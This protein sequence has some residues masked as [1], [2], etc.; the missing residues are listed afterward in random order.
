MLSC[1]ANRKTLSSGRRL[2][3]LSNNE[4][5]CALRTTPQFNE[6]QGAA[7]LDIHNT[8]MVLNYLAVGFLAHSFVPP[9]AGIENDHLIVP[10]H[11][12]TRKTTHL[13]VDANKE[14]CIHRDEIPSLTKTIDN[15]SL[16]AND[17]HSISIQK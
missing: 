5:G 14:F 10:D 13:C 12:P 7:A 2:A 6:T 11:R 16:Q 4:V 9:V 17:A 8:M 3:T 15:D 1:T